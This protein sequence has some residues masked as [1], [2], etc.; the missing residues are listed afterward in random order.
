[1]KKLTI[2]FITII[3]I[4]ALTACGGSGEDENKIVGKYLISA[5]TL[6]GEAM[7]YGDLELMGMQGDSIDFQENGDVEF[8]LYGMSGSVDVDYKN[9]TM[10]VE[11]ETLSFKIVGDNIELSGDGLDITFTLESSPD[12]EEIKAEGSSIMG[13]FEDGLDDMVD[14]A[15]DEFTGG[16]FAAP[17]Y[18][19]E[20]TIA[21]ETLSNPSDWY[22]IVTISDYVGEYPE[23]EGEHEAWGYIDEDDQGTY[24]EVYTDGT[25]DDE[26]SY[27]FMSFYIELENYTFFPVI[28][29][30]A[31]IVDAALTEDDGIWVTPTLMNGVLSATYEYELEGESFTLV[32]ELAMI[33]GSNTGLG[34]PVLDDESVGDS[35]PTSDIQTVEFTL[36]EL[37]AL[38]DSFDRT[39][40]TY[41]DM[42]AH[43]G[44]E[45][46]FDEE[47][48]NTIYYKYRPTDDDYKH[49][50]YFVEERDGQMMVVGHRIELEDL[51]W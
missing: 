48:G 21:V 49:V 1:M 31:W 38:V 32:Y 11:G 39:G 41:D 51:A 50:A 22:G 9:S 12:W 43:F 25:Y 40:K 10:E 30:N 47:I 17:G 20:Q 18:G 29:D 15:M 4:F 27:G 14:D 37:I 34:D 5:T 35:E 33:E 46:E 16:E 6:D 3:M 7:N 2:M 24:F 8:T 19:T 26:N 28:D 45:P 44:G 36:E 13:E 23:M 42:V